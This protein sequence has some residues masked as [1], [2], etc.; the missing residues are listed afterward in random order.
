M[1][2]GGASTRMGSNKALATVAGESLLS[3]VVNA[4]GHLGPVSIVGGDPSLLDHLSD[5]HRY[6]H[7]PDET[8]GS[9]PF[10]A[11][12]TALQLLDGAALSSG[13]LSSGALSL[14]ALLLS[15]DL[16]APRPDD[17]DLLLHTRRAC[18]A[19]IAVPLVGGRRQWHAIAL[20]TRINPQ[21]IARYDSGVRSLVRGFSGFSESVVA[22]S[23]PDFFRDVDTPEELQRL[24]SLVD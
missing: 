11:L 14:E 17:L 9:G 23:S 13:A 12:I 18:D 3:R 4:A 10:A 2:A 8:P 19:D 6:S 15:C 24:R 22:T 16:A 20:S 1:L 5:P 7:I 21:L